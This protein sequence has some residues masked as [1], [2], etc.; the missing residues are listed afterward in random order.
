MTW[1]FTQVWLWSSAA[2]LL[3][4][5]ATW[6][7]FVLPLNRRIRSLRRE[8]EEWDRLA[9]E[10]WSHERV[11][12]EVAEPFV[13]HGAP[14]A[15]AW[16]IL[17]GESAPGHVSEP[18]ELGRTTDAVPV[19]DAVPTGD[20]APSSDRPFRTGELSGYWSLRAGSPGTA[21][22]QEQ[23]AARDDAEGARVG[24]ETTEVRAPVDER[25]EHDVAPDAGADVAPAPEQAPTADDNSR[26]YEARARTVRL[27]PPDAAQQGAGGSSQ[28][29][30]NTWFSEN[31]SAADA[32]AAPSTGDAG[33]S[34]DQQRGEDE[35]QSADRSSG[36]AG[37][38]LSGQLRSLFEPLESR[39]AG[40]PPAAGGAAGAPGVARS[41]PNVP[42]PAPEEETQ[43]LPRR[44]PGATNRPGTPPANR[45]GGAADDE[46]DGAPTRQ[47]PPVRASAG[48]WPTGNEGAASETAA[49]SPEEWFPD[50]VNPVADRPDEGYTVKG[51]FASRQYH[52]PDSPHFERVAA[53]VWFRS[54]AEAEQ[55]GFEPWDGRSRG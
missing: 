2:F 38:S 3:G 21:Q 1:L 51:H 33:G 4:A 44:V 17:P 23:A 37:R 47:H 7:L 48:E 11:P 22:E 19:D 41:K 27:V 16:D 54:G 29:S 52:T 39:G 43:V 10:E 5:V 35:G 42:E 28:G 53:E 15:T 55:A 20:P 46:G 18:P 8:L 31:E 25:V 26:R 50:E 49:G 32:S 40:T 24:N 45:P 13:D 6:L 14:D 34:G 12:Y 9:A 36:S 30:G